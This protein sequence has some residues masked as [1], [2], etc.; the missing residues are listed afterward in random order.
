[1]FLLSF[2]VI[3]LNFF[4]LLMAH[5]HWLTLNMVFVILILSLDTVPLYLVMSVLVWGVLDA[6][7]KGFEPA[8]PP[9]PICSCCVIHLPPMWTFTIL[10]A[11][12][13]SLHHFSMPQLTVSSN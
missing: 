2:N 13:P 8:D 9:L 1:M 11:H 10:Q 6:L 3:A 5:S 7:F 12:S 4:P